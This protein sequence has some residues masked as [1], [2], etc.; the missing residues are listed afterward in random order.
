VKGKRK[1]TQ[2]EMA[3]EAYLYYSKL[4]DALAFIPAKPP[5]ALLETDFIVIKATALLILKRLE[6][7]RDVKTNKILSRSSKRLLN[8]RR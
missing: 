2:L 1:K 8:G 6:V 7:F 4:I 5:K 3:G